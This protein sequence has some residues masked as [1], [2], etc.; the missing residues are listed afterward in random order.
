MWGETGRQRG[1][2]VAD[3]I[4]LIAEIADTLKGKSRFVEAN[5][6]DGNELRHTPRQTVEL[7]T[8]AQDE[9]RYN[10]CNSGSVDR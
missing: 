7:P 4:V 6:F 2:R 9:F 1:R 3:D 8:D 10:I 5:W